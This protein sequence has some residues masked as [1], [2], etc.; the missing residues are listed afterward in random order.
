MSILDY[1]LASQVNNGDWLEYARDG[2]FWGRGQQLQKD[3]IGRDIQTGMSDLMVNFNSDS[4][5][6][7]RGFWLK[8][9]GL[10][11]NMKKEESVNI[12]CG[13]VTPSRTYL[14]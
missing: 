14:I 12:T 2:D 10:G 5:S 8:Y 6:E 13:K 11:S 9:Q 3:D 7:K 4:R 1:D